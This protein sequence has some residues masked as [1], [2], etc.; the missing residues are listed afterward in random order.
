MSQQNDPL[1]SLSDKYQKALKEINSL[2]SKLEKA[3]AAEKSSDTATH[4]IQGLELLTFR[5]NQADLI[6]YV[7]TP[8]LEF[9]FRFL[10]NIESS[11]FLFTSI[12]ANY[13]HG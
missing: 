4:S 3:K 5:I 2:R 9:F 8:F 11:C 1:E 10:K 12:F 6:E 7:N 13:K